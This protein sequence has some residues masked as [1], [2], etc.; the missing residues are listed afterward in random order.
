MKWYTRIAMGILIF[1]LT[2]IGI[3]A[4]I[5][6]RPFT[7]FIAFIAVALAIMIALSA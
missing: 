3:S 2:I 4:I 1:A 7:G 5:I 6:G